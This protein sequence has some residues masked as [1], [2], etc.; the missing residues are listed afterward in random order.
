MNSIVA[1][2]HERR[3]EISVIRAVGAIPNQLSKV[4]LLEGI[5]L[6][7]ISGFIWG[8]AEYP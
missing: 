4:I 8:I 7:L 5:L 6:G 3:A 2:I 1:S